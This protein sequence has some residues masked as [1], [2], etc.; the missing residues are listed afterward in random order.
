MMDDGCVFVLIGIVVI[1]FSVLKSVF[2]KGGRYNLF[3]LGLCALGSGLR[4]LGEDGLRMSMNG[5]MAILI[6]LVP[7]EVAGW[8]LCEALEKIGEYFEKR[9]ERK[10][11]FL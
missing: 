7:I 9:E 11:R 10:R 8:L 6:F 5:I 3:I 2:R 1:L 4:I